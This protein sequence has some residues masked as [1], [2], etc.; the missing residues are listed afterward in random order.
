MSLNKEKAHIDLVIC[1]PKSM[2]YPL[3][4]YFILEHLDY[5]NKVIIVFTETNAGIDYSDFVKSALKGKQFIFIDPPPLESGQDWRDQAVNL[6]LEK[7]SAHWV[8]FTEQDLFVTSPAFWSILALRMLEY[9]VIGYKEGN[10]MHPANMLVKREFINKTPRYFGIVEGKMD[11]FGKFYFGLRFTGARIHAMK[12]DPDQ[13][14]GTF[15]HMNGL[16]HNLSLVQR[17]DEPNHKVYEFNEYL[18]MSLQISP[19][20]DRYKN[21]VEGYLGKIKNE[22]IN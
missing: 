16:S 1:W 17:G 11:H 9:D 12:Y 8:W 6:A 15:Y 10:R 19:L 20:D 2:D 21:M 18:K 22:S 3:W 14:I 7:S 13:N 5:F 4:R